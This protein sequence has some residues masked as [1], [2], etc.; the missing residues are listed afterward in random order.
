MKK[1]AWITD[2]TCGLPPEFIEEN[3]IYVVPLNVIINGVSYKE[4][5]DITKDEFYVRLQEPG[6]DA[7]TSQAT[8]GDFIELY[9]ELKKEYDCGIAIHASSALTGTY[10]SSVTAAEETGFSVEVIDSKIGN[11]ALGKMIRNG[12]ELQ[13]QGQ[14]YE[15]I[16][17]RVREY[18]ALAEM[19]LLPSSLDQLKKSGRVSTGQAILASLLNINLLLRFDDGKVIVED[20]IRSKKRA[21]RSLYSII[22]NAVNKHQLEEICVMH[23]GVLDVAQGWKE[24]LEKMHEQIKVKIKTLVPVAGVHTG[25]GTMAVSWLCNNKA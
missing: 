17:A 20:K 4:D 24:E 15:A 10:S 11:Y 22:E 12:L 1:I 9:E 3:N 6:V 23:A 5:I 14:S 21:K 16:V 13:A 8:L 19:Y 2:S 7:K 25:Y 18:P